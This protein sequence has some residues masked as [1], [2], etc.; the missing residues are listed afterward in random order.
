MRKQSVIIFFILL[1]L[2]G[3]DFNKQ[4]RKTIGKE[5]KAAKAEMNK[6]IDIAKL[7]FKKLHEK[8]LKQSTDSIFSSKITSLYVDIFMTSK[9]ID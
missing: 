8:A 5:V 3:C 9:Y 4:V 1:I 2:F 7:N 6:D